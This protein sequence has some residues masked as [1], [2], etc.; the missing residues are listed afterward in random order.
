MSFPLKPCGNGKPGIL[1]I[2]FGDLFF[3]IIL[4]TNFAE[5]PKDYITL[6][7]H[8]SAGTINFFDPKFYG[9][10]AM[11]SKQKLPP[12]KKFLECNAIEGPINF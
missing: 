1:F 11:V 4:P 10:A 8:R 5:D 7:S 9:A 3:A 12:K 6:P 2:P